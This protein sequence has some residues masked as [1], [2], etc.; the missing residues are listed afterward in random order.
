M[1]ELSVRMTAAAYRAVVGLPAG[2]LEAPE[3]AFLA[4]VV[5]L[6]HTRGWLVYHTHDSRR[7]APGFPD[8]VLTRPGRLIFAEIKTARG[9]LTAA[10]ETWLDLLRHSV[11][12]VEIFVWRPGDWAAIQDALRYDGEEEGMA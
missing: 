2:A 9:K 10:Q 1:A 3:S 12:G 5:M 8:L 4:R 11:P 7:S 6:A